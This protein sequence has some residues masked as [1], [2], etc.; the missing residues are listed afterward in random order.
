MSRLLLSRRR[1]FTLIELLVVIAIIAIL[2]GLLLPAIQKVR[3]AAARMQCSNNLKQI[4][5]AVHTYAEAKDSN[6]PYSQLEG[7]PSN[8]QPPFTNAN[9]GVSSVDR[10]NVYVQL[11]PYIEQA[12]LQKAI[13]SGLDSNGVVTANAESQPWNTK[14]PG[15]NIL[16]RHVRIKTLQCP[17]DSGIAANGRSANNGDW[18]AASYGYNFQVFGGSGQTWVA[19]VPNGTGG[20]MTVNAARWDQWRAS[21]RINNIP[22]GTSQTI[23]FAEKMGACRQASNG[24]V[25]N[26]G[27]LALHHAG[28]NEWS[29]EVALSRQD[30]WSK[31]YMIPQIQPI[32]GAP[33]TGS[34]GTALDPYCDSS[35]PSTGHTDSSMVALGDGSVR[36]VNP[37]VSQTTWLSVLL[38]GDRTQPGSDW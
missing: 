19:S 26:A 21:F 33:P 9:G 34:T 28:H 2:I 31:W 3:E 17:S 24:L 37:T 13:Y 14:V 22:D 8:D 36:T 25:G 32:N 10:P 30:T 7:S 16:A 5:L 20:T 4:T 23:F 29:P 27:A 1:A 35:R 38:P 15:S 11:L 6:L 18:V 12:P